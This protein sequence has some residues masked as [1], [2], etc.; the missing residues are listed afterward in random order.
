M[1]DLIE[2]IVN[3]RDTNILVSASAGAG[4][5]TLL[6]KRL[7]SRII[8]DRVSV[9]NICALT[10]SEAAAQ[11][12]KD[13]LKLALHQAFDETLDQ[14]LKSFLYTQLTLIDTAMIST[15]HSFALSIISDFAFVLNL[16]PEISKNVLDDNTRQILFAECCDRV[17][18]EAIKHNPV[19]FEA[20]QHLVS[21]SEFDFSTIKEILQNIYK[22]RR[23]QL[24]PQH[25]DSMCIAIHTNPLDFICEPL[26][27]DYFHRCEEIS[28]LLI[29]AQNYRRLENGDIS[30]FTL[31]LERIEVIKQEFARN[32]LANAIEL[33]HTQW[34]KYIP[35]LPNHEP[36][37]E[38]RERL[39]KRLKELV[40][41][42]DDL[43]THISDIKVLL[44]HIHFLIKCVQNLSTLM[45][46]RKAKMKVIE[47]DDMEQFAYSILIHPA[48][49]VRT[50][51]KEQYIDIFV[52]EFQDTN[53]IQNEIINMISRGNNVFRVGDVKQSIYRFRGAKPQLMRSI[54]KEKASAVFVLPHNFRSKEPI[55]EFNNTVFQH[56]MN[57]SGFSDVYTPEDKVTPGIPQQKMNTNPV[58]YVKVNQSNTKDKYSDY[59]K[60]F[61]DFDESD[62]FD[63][64]DDFEDFDDLDADGSVS[65][66]KHEKSA[67]HVKARF[68]TQDIL[69]KTSNQKATFKDI[70]VLVKTHSQK[71]VLK[72]YFDKFGI[73]HFINS[74]QGFLKH[75]TV[76]QMLIL[77]KYCLF[78]TE[79]HLVGV[80]LSDYTSLTTN[81]ISNLRLEGSITQGLN[82]YY[83][84]LATE[85]E[86]L[87]QEVTSSSLFDAMHSLCQFKN[88]YYLR[89]SQG[90]L[91]IDALIQQA[92]NFESNHLGGLF[93]FIDSLEKL[94]DAKIAEAM[95][96]ALGDNVVKVMTIHKSK[97]LQFPIVYVFNDESTTLHANKEQLII[98]PNFGFTLRIKK[99]YN[100]EVNNLIR[101]AFIYLDKKATYEESLRLWYV[102]LTRAENEMICV[103][104][105]SKRK[106]IT[107][108]VKA[109]QILTSKGFNDLLSRLDTLIPSHLLHT[110]EI[111]DTNLSSIDIE[112]ASISERFIILPLLEP[113]QIQP[114]A[115]SPLNHSS[116]LK[117]KAMGTLIH[118]ILAQC[119]ISNDPISVIERYSH[120]I[121]Y[122]DKQGMIAFFNHT[123]FHNWVNFEKF[124][125]YP[126]ITQNET[127]I[128]QYYLDLLLKSDDVWIIVDFKTDRVNSMHELAMRYRDQLLAYDEAVRPYA[129]TL[130]SVIYSIYLKEVIE[131]MQK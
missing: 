46:T 124:S 125:E 90:K 68:I 61:E 104:L 70:C 77:A 64:F 36:Y 30:L 119:I 85:L 86:Q 74:P 101:K 44:P 28:E 100:I 45:K 8:V 16:D 52:D 95:D 14:D 75:D 112:E 29:A 27:E 6:I 59:D 31:L 35:T 116:K 40:S 103:G 72:Y 93:A 92:V 129:P 84:T 122:E 108:P 18:E 131:I 91:N 76:V 32:A 58:M 83:R 10:F 97:G 107:I 47:F 106:S 33:M 12:M 55:V 1:S 82:T 69:A 81:D 39:N 111:D 65:P 118:S 80:L 38:V 94:E 78:P 21:T 117:S 51:Y 88:F 113:K 128:H 50:F 49:D 130:K 109:S 105:N 13:R 42:I 37:A 43:E 57:V 87:R 62:D 73:P 24:D 54:I 102:A 4:K 98:N 114:I 96:V 60:E 25:F 67:N 7:L 115:L 22:V 34:I 121:S 48:F 19:E 26:C 17:I 2:H 53:D 99:E 3:L 71:E 79:Y 41:S 5:T 63:E 120:T 66:S 15:I 127:G 89:D 9:S 110:I 123:Y 23:V 126:L 56:L 11:E 20:L